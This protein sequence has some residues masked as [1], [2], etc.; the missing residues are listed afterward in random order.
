MKKRMSVI[1]PKVTPRKFVRVLKGRRSV[2]I[3][4][5]AA[6]NCIGI[7]W[8]GIENTAPTM[9]DEIISER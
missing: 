1:E 7:K 3:A 2:D 9:S 8:I 6:K 5:P 4:V